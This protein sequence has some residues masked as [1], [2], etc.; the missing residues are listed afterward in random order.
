ME[1]AAEEEPPVEELPD[2]KNGFLP[3]PTSQLRVFRQ[4]HVR[5]HVREESGYWRWKGLFVFDKKLE[6]TLPTCSAM[7]SGLKDCPNT[8]SPG[9]AWPKPNTLFN[10]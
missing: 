5:T 1:D 8:T 9:S 2:S 7:G 3:F 10:R 6:R 4:P